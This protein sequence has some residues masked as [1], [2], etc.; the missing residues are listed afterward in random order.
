MSEIKPRWVEG[1]PVCQVGIDKH[2]ECKNWVSD[3]SVR[4]C[5]TTLCNCVGVDQACWP[6]IREQRDGERRLKDA[7]RRELCRA[8]TSSWERD[9]NG[10]TRGA[11]LLYA[12]KRGWDCFDTEPLEYFSDDQIDTK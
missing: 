1:E 3:G 5:R 10:K 11:P 12:K 4:K 7:A 9:E 2:P 8:K 6:A